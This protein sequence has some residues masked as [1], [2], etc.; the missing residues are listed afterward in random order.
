MVET[1]V[2]F[3]LSTVVEAPVEAVFEALTDPEKHSAFTGAEATGEPV[4]GGVFTAWDG[5]IEGRYLEIEP[6]TRILQEW[7]TSEWPAGSPVSLVEFRLVSAG[8][9]TELTL[10][11]SEV[12]ASQAGSYKQGWVD[13]YWKPLRAYFEK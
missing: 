12:P 10:I 13:Y 5:Y 1:T 9:S 8:D 4:E 7:I 6:P 2:S 3:E 11:H